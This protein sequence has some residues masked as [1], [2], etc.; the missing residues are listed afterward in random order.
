MDKPI[1]QYIQDSITDAENAVRNL[2]IKLLI[3]LAYKNISQIKNSN[4]TNIL[5]KRYL[6]LIQ[7]IHRKPIKIIIKIAQ[8]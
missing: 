1:K 4:T 2:G 7:Q 5:H 8:L 6:H 3:A